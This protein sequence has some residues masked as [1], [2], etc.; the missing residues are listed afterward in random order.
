MRH[1]ER[2]EVDRTRELMIGAE[3]GVELRSLVVDELVGLAVGEPPQ[4]D[5]WPL[6]IAHTACNICIRATS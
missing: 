6:V 4:R 3:P 1:K 5:L 2:E